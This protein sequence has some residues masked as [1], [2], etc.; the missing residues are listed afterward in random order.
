M[1]LRTFPGRMSEERK[2][3]RPVVGAVHVLRQQETGP[4]G[5]KETKLVHVERHDEIHEV[6]TLVERQIAR[7]EHTARRHVVRGVTSQHDGA[8]HVWIHDFPLA[9]VLEVLVVRHLLPKGVELVQ[10]ID[11]QRLHKQNHL[12]SLAA[13]LQRRRHDLAVVARSAVRRRRRRCRRCSRASA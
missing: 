12:V 10:Q 5:V 9:L 1:M 11:V 3:P 4:E 8:A 6:E 13:V 2:G 7:V